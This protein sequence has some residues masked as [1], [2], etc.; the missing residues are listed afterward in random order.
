MGSASKIMSMVKS[1][2]NLEL[3]TVSGKESDCALN[4][5]KLYDSTIMILFQHSKTS[6]IKVIGFFSHVQVRKEPVMILE[7]KIAL[8]HAPS[9]QIT[10]KNH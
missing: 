1:R 10:T 2:P 7:S 8:E 4:H 3:K 9:N 6:L 5:I